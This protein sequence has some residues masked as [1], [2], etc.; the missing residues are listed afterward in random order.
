ML[1]EVDSIPAPHRRAPSAAFLPKVSSMDLQVGS[2]S[3]RPH[4]LLRQWL[5]R[6]LYARRLIHFTQFPPQLHQLA[7]LLHGR[8]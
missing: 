6:A 5:R 1:A 2:I 3:P 7:Q 8:K 4:S